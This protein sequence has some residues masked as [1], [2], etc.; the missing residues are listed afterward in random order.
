MSAVKTEKVK[1]VTIITP[2]VL[3]ERIAEELIQLGAT[4]FSTSKLNGHG[5]HGPRK[6]GIIDGA[7]IRIE[8]IVHAEL[9]QEILSQLGTRYPKDALVAYSMDVEAI[10]PGHFG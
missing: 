3:E 6:Y 4:G 8:V 2:F 1:L 7:N 9:A 5:A 10:P